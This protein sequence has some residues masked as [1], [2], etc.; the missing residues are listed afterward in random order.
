MANLK[1][2]KQLKPECN[3]VKR[4]IFH[5]KPGKAEL[6][7]GF[8][9]RRHSSAVSNDV[10]ESMHWHH[11]YRDEM[12]AEFS[13]K[14][15]IFHVIKKYRKR[16]YCTIFRINIKIKRQLKKRKCMLYY[17]GCYGSSRN[18]FNY[19]IPQIL[20]NGAKILEQ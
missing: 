2:F 19:Q 1:R 4:V 9:A 18:K 14:K 12:C 15:T 16:S 13:K 11:L 3:G 5:K 17:T 7:I 8:R 6:V 10:H 20:Q